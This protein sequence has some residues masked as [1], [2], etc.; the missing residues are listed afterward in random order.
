MDSL[1]GMTVFTKVAERASFTAAAHDLKL[2]K[3]AVSKQITRLE[4]RLGVQLIHRTTRRL[5]LTEVGQAYYERAKRVVE[6][7]E[8]AEQAI[9][10]LHGDLRGTIRINAPLSYG[11]RKLCPLVT[12]FMDLHPDLKIDMTFSDRVRDLIDDGFDMGVRIAQLTDSSLIA[13]K[14]GH[15]EL[16]VVASPDYWEKHGKPAH[17]DDLKNHNCLLYDYRTNPNEWKF[18][19][20]DGPLPVTVDGSFRAN[21]G[22]ALVC[23]ASNGQGV[24]Y[25]PTF[26]VDNLIQTGQL[27]TALEDFTQDGIGIYAV[28]PHNRH[29]SAKVRGFVDFLVE[30]LKEG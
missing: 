22:E 29:L 8:E 3:S 25:V 23:A 18:K 16:V 7:A 1:S 27:T 13:R 2:S 4:D 15:T 17:P 19:G 24:F 20:P 14:L 12:K 10:S 30:E 28:W 5:H 6:D 21:N 9:A 11:L 26:L